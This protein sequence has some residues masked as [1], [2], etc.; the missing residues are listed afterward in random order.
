[1]STNSPNL[2]K[3]QRREAARAEALALKQK[4][5]ARDRRNRI[6]TLGVLG[7]VLVALAAIV[8]YILG[9]SDTGSGPEVEDIPLSEVAT[10]PAPAR[11]DGGIPVGTD[12]VAGGEGAADAPEVGVY[13]DYMC[14]ICGDFEAA[15]T[16]SIEAMMS[17]GAANVVFHPVSILD[18]ASAG[19][20]FSTRSAAAAAWVADRAPEHFLEFHD[21]LFANQPAERSRG[22][23]NREMADLAVEAGVPQ[24][25]ADGIADGTAHQ[26]YGQWVYSVTRQVTADEALANPQTGGFGTP[27]VTIDGERWGGD[28]RDP[29]ALQQAVAEAAR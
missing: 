28:W 17:S 22:L 23:S 6:V 9:Q 29:A 5:A 3:A 4:Q 8:I 2:S 19:T 16:A 10:V 27:T 1:M 14:P 7:V 26:D 20:A 13:F 11:A 12:G 15:N 21:T 18:R 24:D 25:V